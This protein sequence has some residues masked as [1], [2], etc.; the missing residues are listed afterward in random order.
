MGH[1]K[2]K[3]TEICIVVRKR[4]KKRHD[5]IFIHSFLIVLFS[6]K[7]RIDGGGTSRQPLTLTRILSPGHAQNVYAGST[8]FAST[9]GTQFLTANS[10]SLDVE[11]L[12]PFCM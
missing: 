2:I 3:T 5:V 8:V 10:G 4:L 6:I 11:C 1:L 7:V 9:G 12:F